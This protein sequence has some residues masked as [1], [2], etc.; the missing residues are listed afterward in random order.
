MGHYIKICLL[1]PKSLNGVQKLSQHLKNALTSLLVYILRINKAW[2]LIKQT[3]YTIE[4]ISEKVGYSSALSFR[5]AF[6]KVVGMPPSVY[7]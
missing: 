1:Y 5:R 7:R 4:E 3:D 2:E 6:K